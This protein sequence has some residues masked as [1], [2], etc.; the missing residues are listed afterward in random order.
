MLNAGLVA[1]IWTKSAEQLKKAS[2]YLEGTTG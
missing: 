2:P 1:L